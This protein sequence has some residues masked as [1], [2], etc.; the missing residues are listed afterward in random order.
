MGKIREPKRAYTC[1][2]W[3]KLDD[4][5]TI[6]SIAKVVKLEVKDVLDM[7]LRLGK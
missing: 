3:R 1:G 5:Y 2:N 4:E 6:S 7:L